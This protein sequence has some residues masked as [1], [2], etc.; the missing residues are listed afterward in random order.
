MLS[1]EDERELK[2]MEEEFGETVGKKMFML[3][4]RKTPKRPLCAGC[5]CEL[6]IDP[7]VI[8][9]EILISDDEL[10]LVKLCEDCKKEYHLAVLSAQKQFCGALRFINDE[11]YKIIGR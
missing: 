2:R 7:V 10:A 3:G 1:K 4:Y 9:T 8:P 5:G 6:S 11:N